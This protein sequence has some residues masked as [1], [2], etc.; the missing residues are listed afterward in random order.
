MRGPYQ[1]RNAFRITTM[2]RNTFRNYGRK[3]VR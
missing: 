2:L 3:A 1:L